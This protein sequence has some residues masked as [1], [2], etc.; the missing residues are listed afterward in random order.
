[1]YTPPEKTN[2]TFFR[3]CGRELC[4][5]GGCSKNPLARPS[6]CSGGYEVPP[7]S[8]RASA[9][10]PY[11]QR[12]ARFF[13]PAP[14]GAFSLSPISLFQKEKW[15]RRRQGASLCRGCGE[16][17]ATGEKHNPSV[18][19]S[20][21]HLPLHR[22]G[23]RGGARSISHTPWRARADPRTPP[24]RCCRMCCSRGSAYSA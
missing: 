24:W 8:F 4:E 18:S 15:G 12:E 23:K 14:A 16:R 6:Q 1:M 19:P 9:R 13:N 3:A 21:R 17:A 2:C 7:R 22:G 11:K 5:A 20:A 10:A